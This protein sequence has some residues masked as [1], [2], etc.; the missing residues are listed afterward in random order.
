MTSSSSNRV[1]LITGCSSGFGQAFAQAVIAHGDH[2]I[3]TARHVEQIEALAGAQPDQVRALELDVTNAR[4]AQETVKAALDT[5]G[6][7]DVLVNNAGY[8]L[9]GA[10][11]ELSE[12]Q[13]RQQLEVNLLG[14]MNVTRAVL[15][16]MRAQGWGHLVQISSLGGLAGFAGNS[17]YSAS[18]FALEGWSEVLSRELAPFGIKVT[19]VEPGGFRTEWAGRSMI[20]AAP[21]AAYD[22]VMTERRAGMELANGRQPGDPARAAQALIAVVESEHPPLRLPLGTDAVTIIRQHLQQQLNDLDRWE[23]LSCSTDFPRH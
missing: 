9:F 1:W 5:F 17:A 6:H 7:I 3:A 23:S 19:I 13:I 14:A 12:A 21:L 15:P 22:V 4:Q 16:S 10:F 2:L 8:G 11:E 18:K 20:K